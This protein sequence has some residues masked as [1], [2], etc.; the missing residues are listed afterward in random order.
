MPWPIRTCAF[1]VVATFAGNAR[2]DDKLLGTR[3]PEWELS[4]WVNSAPLSLRKDLAGKVV[5]VRWWFG[6]GCPLCSATAPA[7]KDFHE[8]YHDRGMVVVGVY[9]HKSRGPLEPDKVKA[10]AQKMGM[11]FPVAIDHHWK[12][13]K[14]WWLDAG[15]RDYTSVTFLLDRKGAIRH[16][17]PGGKYVIGDKDYKALKAKIEELL[18]ED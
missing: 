13:L 2:A 17:H 10:L 3:P 8:K 12:T 5:L 6:P 7:L 4:D 15:L 14:A 9:H 18:A 16:I 1:L 11:K